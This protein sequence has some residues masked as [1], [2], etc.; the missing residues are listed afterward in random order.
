L[1]MPEQLW[2]RQKMQGQLST[3]GSG[4]KLRED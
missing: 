3:Q 2:D 1:K 4:R